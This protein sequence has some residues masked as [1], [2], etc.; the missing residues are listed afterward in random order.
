VSLESPE[1]EVTL[2][3]YEAGVPAGVLQ[4]MRVAEFNDLDSVEAILRREAD[5]I[6]AIITEPMMGSGGCIPANPEF[7]SGLRRLADQYGV[8]LIFD[9]TM[10][11]RLAYG[12]LQ[13]TYGVLPDL[14][15]MGKWLGG[16]IPFGVFGGRRDI[17]K[18]FDPSD[19]SAFRV[20]HTGTFCG[21][22]LACAAGIAAAELFD[23]A[24]VERLNKLGDRL[25]AGIEQVARERGVACEV[26]GIGSVVNEHW[27]RGS[28]K[29]YRDAI[30]LHVDDEEILDM[31]HLEL[32]NRG[33]YSCH[34]GML[35]L[36]TPMAE[37]DVDR[38]LEALGGTMDV[39][40]PCL[41]ERWPHLILG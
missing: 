9:E 20:M 22:D 23:E 26:T 7:L 18:A 39:L 38:Y 17:M 10:T 5:Q 21:N 31:R 41:E 40:R 3:T 33:I 13:S 37:A 32:M 35:V 25:R 30:S 15:A 2:G 4:D 24:A 16:G 1:P 14:T 19:P 6:A 36:S 28:I 8:L 12:G 29:S 11:S 34:R 27:I